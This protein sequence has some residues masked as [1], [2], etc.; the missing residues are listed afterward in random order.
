MR[1]KALFLMEQLGGTD[2]ARSPMVRDTKS[3]VQGL[4]AGLP[5]LEAL[6]G[7][8]AAHPF[9]VYLSLCNMVGA[10][11]ASGAS[12]LPP[13]LG[14]YDHSNCRPAFTEIRDY[15]ARSLDRVRDSVASIPFQYENDKFSL[16]I[17]PAWLER[18]LIVAVRPS[19]SMTEADL[20]S[21]LR[22]SLIASRSKVETLWEMRVMGAG[23]RAIDDMPDLEIAR[24]RGAVLF[25]I[26][27]DAQF[28]L[29]DEPLDIWNADGRGGRRR[30]L[31]IVLY[32]QA[33]EGRGGRSDPRTLAVVEGR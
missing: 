5:Q 27:N 4:I 16:V 22:N 23:R 29:P 8:N 32:V 31:E 25:E 6:L 15:I 2:A 21:W 12:A 24:S 26:D 20:V 14:R 17:Q 10:M 19:V 28:I 30:P 11:A 13:V 33:G 7:S 1:E 3:E 18:R 9:A